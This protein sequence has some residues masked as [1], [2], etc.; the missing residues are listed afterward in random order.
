MHTL[1]QNP[2]T[3]PVPVIDFLLKKTVNDIR[4]AATAGKVSRIH[5][6]DKRARR[7]EVLLRDT[8]TVFENLRLIQAEIANANRSADGIELR[9]I[10]ISITKCMIDY[11]ML[12]LTPHIKQGTVQVG[13]EMEV[14]TPFTVFTTD[15]MRPGNKLRA[16]GPIKQFYSE[17]MV[18][19]GDE[20]V[21]K[22]T[23]VGI[24]SLDTRVALESAG[25]V[26]KPQI[27]SEI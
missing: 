1:E 7:L 27:T 25:A 6:L 10:S 24:W 2:Y 14:H 5:I 23:A 13:E 22:E 3:N 21:L 18:K 15:V 12:I 16:R 20:V 19:V 9:S 17:G 11:S 26:K 8:K 4:M